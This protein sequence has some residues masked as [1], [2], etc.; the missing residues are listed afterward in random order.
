M[1]HPFHVALFM[2]HYDTGLLRRSAP[3]MPWRR[4]FAFGHAIRGGLHRRRMELFQLRECGRLYF[5]VPLTSK[6]AFGFEISGP[7]IAGFHP[8]RP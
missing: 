1:A 6:N 7:E 5:L 4:E 2:S 8:R 3:V